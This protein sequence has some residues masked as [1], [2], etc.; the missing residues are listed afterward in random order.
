MNARMPVVFVSH[1]SPMHATEP[2]AA[3]IAWAE[4]AREIE[5][6]H[7]APRAIL[8]VSAHWESNIPMLTGSAQPETIHDFGGFPPELYRILY[9]APGAP[10]LAEHIQSVLHE[11]GICTGIEPHRGL[12]HGAWV[13]LLHMF[14]Q[15]DIPVLQLS[16]QSDLGA[17]HHLALGRALER[18]RDEGV[19][20]IASGHM[21]HNLRDFF[22]AR[23]RGDFS[24]AQQFRDWIDERV[25]A[26][27]I[28]ELL[29][30][31]LRAPSALRAHPTPEHF[32][33][34]FVALGAAG[35]G[36]RASNVFSEMAGGVLAMDAYRFD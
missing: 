22:V 8:I 30:W 12:D 7:E 20:I 33:P 4:L 36:Y 19:L 14:P 32:L 26:G 31:N 13:P 29:D 28:D 24:Y 23:G 16:V 21:T 5:A 1:G 25:I 3:G 17:R 10:G 34:L 6:R 15:A 35:D 9:P 27:R 2:G 18:L 11:A